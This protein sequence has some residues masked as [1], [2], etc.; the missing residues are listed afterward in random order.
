MDS[1]LAEFECY[2]AETDHAEL[3]VGGY[4]GDVR[5]FL[6]WFEEAYPEPFSLPL[7]TSAVVRNYRQTLLDQG[8]R[9]ATINRQ[10]ASLA[11]FA[12]WAQRLGYLQVQRNPVLEVKA[13]PQ[14]PLAPR[15]LDKKEQTKLLHAVTDEVERAMRRYPRL[16][17]LVL[18]DAALVLLMLNTGLRLHEV[19]ALKLSDL[20]ITERGG[21]VIVRQ[22]K[23]G[24]YREVPLNAN[25]R[26]ILH[27]YLNVRPKV[28]STMFFIGL[29]EEGVQGK[30]IRRAVA[31]FAKLAGVEEVSPHTLRH[32]FAKALI[33]SGVGLEKV[34]ALLG[35]SNLNTTRIYITA[36]QRDLEVAVEELEN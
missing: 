31:R 26:R 13:I 15:W 3:T 8:M 21:K 33:D 34:A 30:T 1:L 28:A 36:G 23:G 35:H 22:G 11:A 9:P 25:V 5:R 20:Q 2:L 24:K 14:M 10:L 6:R 32:T 27:D 18:R 16:Q 17:V 7:L 19:E 12:H 4:V 29:H